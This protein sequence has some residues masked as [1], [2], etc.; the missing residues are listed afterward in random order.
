L[1]EGALLAGVGDKQAS[2]MLVVASVLSA[3]GPGEDLRL[4][5]VEQQRVGVGYIR[6]Q[7]RGV[8][9]KVR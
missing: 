2:S 3:T 8:T 4:N 9:V 5:V 7:Q 1:K 6:Y